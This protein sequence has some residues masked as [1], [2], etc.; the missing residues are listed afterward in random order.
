MLNTQQVGGWLLNRGLPVSPNLTYAERGLIRTEEH[1]RADDEA[2]Q[3]E[4]EDDV[5]GRRDEVR[6]QRHELAHRLSIE[7]HEVLDLS[8]GAVLHPRRGPPC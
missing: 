1:A 8:N 5:D 6:H 4:D 2:Q 7:R 3:R